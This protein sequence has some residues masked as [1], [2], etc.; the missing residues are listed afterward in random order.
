[1]FA[2]L[3]LAGLT[4]GALYALVGIGIVLIYKATGAINFAQG[5][6]LMVAGFV[7]YTLHVTLHLPY[8]VALLGAVAACFVLGLLAE[9]IAFRPL[10]NAD[11]ISLVLAT[12][13]LSFMLK[14]F[15]RVVWGGLGDYL[16]FPPLVPNDPIMFGDIILLPQQLVVTGGAVLVI[17]V[18]A[19]FF[20]FTSL[21]RMMQATADNRRA[22]RLVGIRVDRVHALAFAVGAALAGAAAALMA[23]ITLLYPDI[24]FPLFIKGFAAAVFGGLDSLPGT[25]LGAV[26]IGLIESLAGGYVGSGFVDV[27]AFL[28]IMAVLLIRPRGLL[29]SAAL[30]RA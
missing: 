21:G 27:S 6:M 30:R 8:L 28:V 14:G 2:Y 4:N 1:M 13:G 22:A 5:D 20:K 17:V 7:A 11:I 15:G 23:P 26:A 10:A 16:S 29:G 18:F 3:A 25:L 12:V 9:R 19:L 24:G